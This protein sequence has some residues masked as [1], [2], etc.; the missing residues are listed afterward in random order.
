M[1]LYQRADYIS[2]HVPKLKNTIGMINKAGFR[3]DEN[4]GDDRST[5]PGGGIVEET[6][7]VMMPSIAG[8]VAG[9]ALDVFETEPPGA[10]APHQP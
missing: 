7:L 8:K 10:V 9:A 2:V 5:V 3:Q 6:D 1:S 4:R